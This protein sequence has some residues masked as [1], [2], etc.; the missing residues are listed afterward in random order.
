MTGRAA[1]RLKRHGALTALAV[2]L[3]VVDGSAL[4]VAGLLLGRA[5]FVV[6]GVLLGLSSLIVL[7]YWRRHRRNVTELDAARADVAAGLR[8]LARRPPPS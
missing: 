2:L 1:L 6:A 8:A 7:R 4:L 5:G 3:L